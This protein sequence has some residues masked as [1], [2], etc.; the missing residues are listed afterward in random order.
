M[1]VGEDA[2]LAMPNLRMRKLI[3]WLGRSLFVAVLAAGLAACGLVP[4]DEPE[5]PDASITVIA[6]T[7]S[8][9]VSHDREADVPFAEVVLIDVRFDEVVIGAAGQTSVRADAEPIAY[10]V[11]PR[12]ARDYQTFSFALRNPKPGTA[13]VHVYKDRDATPISFKLNIGLDD[14]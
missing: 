14:E 1:L 9:T 5:P 6:G 2:G 3:A 13:T 7:F 10:R 11:E 8:T 4:E 12:Q